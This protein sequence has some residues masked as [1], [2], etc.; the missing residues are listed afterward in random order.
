MKNENDKITS[1]KLE[2]RISINI[3]KSFPHIIKTIDPEGRSLKL[4][5][6]DLYN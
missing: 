3:K 4:K 5:I 6:Q 2:K 1:H